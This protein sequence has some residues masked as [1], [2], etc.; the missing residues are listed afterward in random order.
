MLSAD[1]ADY[2]TNYLSELGNSDGE[3]GQSV[4]YTQYDSTTLYTAG[5]PSGNAINMYDLET[6]TFQSLDTTIP[7]QTSRRSC[8][9]SSDSPMPTL[10]IVGGQYP[11]KLQVLD[12][13]TVS[14][15]NSTSDMAYSHS[16][17]GCLVADD[18]LWAIAGLASNAVEAVN[19]N[20]LN[21]W[22]YIGALQCDL[23]IPGVTEANGLIYVIGGSCDGHSD[24][25]HVIDTAKNSI[26]IHSDSFAFGR[27]SFPVVAVD[28]IIYGFGGVIGSSTV[29]S[30]IT[31]HML[32]IV[33]HEVIFIKYTQ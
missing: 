15:H 27:Y 14:W 29:D 3:Y 33:C 7:F 13:H 20:Y 25:M 18:R 19:I 30:W 17:H 5:G 4:Y 10:Y 22:Q 24:H 11:K 31:L 2:G 12:L 16:Y 9:A 6:L 32:S 28:D 1:F 21:S 23:F 8:I 26:E